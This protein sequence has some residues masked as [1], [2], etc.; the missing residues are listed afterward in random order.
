[1][2]AVIKGATS[3]GP[4]TSGP[5][6]T[7][8]IPGESD[9]FSL[10]RGGSRKAEG[11]VQEAGFAAVQ[12]FLSL[13]PEGCEEGEVVRPAPGTT[14]RRRESRRDLQEGVSHSQEASQSSSWGVHTCPP[15]FLCPLLRWDCPPAGGHRSSADVL[16]GVRAQVG[17][18]SRPDGSQTTQE[19]GKA[20]GHV[21]VCLLYDCQLR[22]AA[23][24]EW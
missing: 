24:Q 17:S 23:L 1:M 20:V 14:P 22:A 19:P 8:V 18:A 21:D 2:T 11:V 13:G 15:V 9:S 16:R 12:L 10:Q 7:G 3:A 5:N 6:G 4:C